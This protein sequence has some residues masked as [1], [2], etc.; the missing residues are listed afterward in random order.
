V[1]G[2]LADATASRRLF[3]LGYVW[4]L[5]TVQ[6]AI[7]IIFIAA[8]GATSSANWLDVVLQSIIGYLRASERNYSSATF[9]SIL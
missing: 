7:T 4:A 2:W 5:S 9:H 1:V 8:V 6:N 3:L